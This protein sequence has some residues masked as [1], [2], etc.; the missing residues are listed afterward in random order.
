METEFI[1]KDPETLN[2]FD[3]VLAEYNRI[4]DIQLDFTETYNKRIHL[5]VCEE[6]TADGYGIWTIRMD[7]ESVELDNIYYYEP[8]VSVIFNAINENNNWGLFV[9]YCDGKSSE[10]EDYMHQELYENYD[11]YLQDL[12]DNKEE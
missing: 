9:I 10:L 6:T 12:E 3:E 1:P 4:N 5:W 8:D 11:N 2:D 7:G